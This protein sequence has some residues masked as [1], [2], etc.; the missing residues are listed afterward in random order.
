[1][2]VGRWVKLQRMDKQRAKVAEIL[3]WVIHLPFS[4]RNKGTELSSSATAKIAVPQR[5]T[6]K[7][8]R[9]LGVVLKDTFHPWREPPTANEAM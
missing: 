2:V 7:P 5:L 9:P 3:E 4:E 6:L 8:W 1:M